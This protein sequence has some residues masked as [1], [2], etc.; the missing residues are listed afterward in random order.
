MFGESEQILDISWR[1]LYYRRMWC[2][3]P[4][5]EACDYEPAIGVARTRAGWELVCTVHANDPKVMDVM[6][7]PQRQPVLV[8]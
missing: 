3:R 5:C 2:Q 1:P 8:A 6:P 7:L 4:M